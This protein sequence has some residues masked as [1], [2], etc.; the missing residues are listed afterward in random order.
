MFNLQRLKR[1][2]IPC[3]EGLLLKKHILFL[4]FIGK[5]TVPAARLRDA[6][7]TEEQLISAYKQCLK[8]RTIRFF[9]ERNSS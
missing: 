7:L 8:V 4:S 2:G 9:I 6:D 1:A 3:P 5:D